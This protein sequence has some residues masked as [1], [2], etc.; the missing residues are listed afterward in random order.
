MAFGK[1][2]QSVPLGSNT[3]LV[4]AGVFPECTGTKTQYW[5]VGSEQFVI[6][7]SVRL[8]AAEVLEQTDT[9]SALKPRSDTWGL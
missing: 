9:A 2:S 5:N 6:L 4:E 3:D 7:R 8:E 1:C